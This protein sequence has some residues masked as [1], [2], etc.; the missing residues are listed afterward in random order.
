MVLKRKK[1]FTQRLE[2]PNTATFVGKGRLDEIREYVKAN[3]IDTVIFD[4]D[5]SPSQLRNIE[6]VLQ[7]L[8]SR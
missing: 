3:N 8:I 2:T 1:R 4:D 5:L 7:V 6:K